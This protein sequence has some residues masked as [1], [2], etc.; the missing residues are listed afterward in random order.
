MMNQETN[1]TKEG[2]SVA[3]VAYITAVGAI[4]A[5]FMNM[6]TKNSFA[7]FHTRQAI[8]IHLLFFLLAPIVTGFNSLIISVSF[9]IFFFTLW[10]YGFLGA[11]QGKKNLVPVIG[12]YF[13]T[14][15]N[16]LA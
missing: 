9:W 5:V 3:T 6:D 10:L 2:K 4:V 8:G 1:Y 12:K 14:W 13:Q 16:K 15:F 7:S 11:M